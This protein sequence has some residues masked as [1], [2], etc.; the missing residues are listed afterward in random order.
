SPASVAA[1]CHFAGYVVIVLAFATIV[2]WAPS[3]VFE[4]GATHKNTFVFGGS[5]LPIPPTVR[6]TDAVRATEENVCTYGVR[7]V[8]SFTTRTRLFVELVVVSCTISRR[9]FGSAFNVNLPFA[10]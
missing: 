1:P 2:F 3:L 9:Y 6:F 4:V 10:S 7:V 5:V 8:R